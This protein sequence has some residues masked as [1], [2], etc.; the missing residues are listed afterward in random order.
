MPEQVVT[1]VDIE[2]NKYEV[3]ISELSWRPSAYGIIIK[4]DSVLLSKQFNG[5]DLPGG[6]I[7]LGE[8]PEAATIREIKEETG[9]DAS[10]PELLHGAT[11]FFKQAHKDGS[12]IQSL[13]LYYRCK[14]DGGELS[15]AG[16]DEYEKSYADMPE[17]V[18][19]KDLG[20]ITVANSYDWRSIVEKAAKQ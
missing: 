20:S 16:F 14:Y 11:S 5:Y 9:I 6:G 17:W 19:I 18:P 7:D 13:Q 2:G 10:E 3:P 4:D 15:N 8:T 1:A 12:V